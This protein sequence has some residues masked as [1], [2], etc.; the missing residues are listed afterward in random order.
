MY[1][2]LA[3]MCGALQAYTTTCH[4]HKLDH[5]SP[6]P[7]TNGGKNTSI[8]TG[9]D[10][11]TGKHHTRYFLTLPFTQHMYIMLQVHRRLY[12]DWLTVAFKQVKT[13]CICPWSGQTTYSLVARNETQRNIDKAL[14][15]G[16]WAQQ[17]LHNRG[18]VGD[19]R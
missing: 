13:H 5:T 2:G 6:T 8:L 17:S 11:Q 18:R 3:N 4:K 12:I 16:F 9:R 10:M 1:N 15:Q 14:P 19:I 7:K